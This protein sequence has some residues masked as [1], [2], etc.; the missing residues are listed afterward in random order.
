MALSNFQ[1][2]YIYQNFADKL[3]KNEILDFV[4]KEEKD[5]YENFFLGSENDCKTRAY[6]YYEDAYLLFE[7]LNHIKG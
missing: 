3:S 4:P 1:L 7:Q 6:S 2:G 5:K